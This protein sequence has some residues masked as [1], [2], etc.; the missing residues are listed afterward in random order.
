LLI[1]ATT[2]YQGFAGRQTKAPLAATLDDL[3]KAAK[4][5]FELLQQAHVADYQKYF[6]R[7]SIYLEPRDAT[8]VSKP[9]PQRIKAAQGEP[10][11]PG[12]AALY[13]NFGLIS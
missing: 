1:A 2:D 4:K 9:T 3:N 7:V 11:D 6:Q 13:F 10:G 5:S 8:A 12:L